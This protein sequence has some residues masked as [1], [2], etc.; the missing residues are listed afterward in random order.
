MVADERLCNLVAAVA[1]RAYEE[2][3]SDEVLSEE[4]IRVSGHPE[5]QVFQR[6][7]RQDTFAFGVSSGN[8]RILGIENSCD[9]A[10]LSDYLEGE[11]GLTTSQAVLQR[12]LITIFG[13]RLEHREQYNDRIADNCENI[14]EDAEAP[15]YDFKSFIFGL[16]LDSSL[17]I[18]DVQ[19]RPRRRN[20]VEIDVRRIDQLLPNG[21]ITLPDKSILQT[22]VLEHSVGGGDDL[23]DQKRGH[24]T[25][26]LTCGLL[27]L[28]ADASYSLV[29]TETDGRYFR[30]G[31]VV[32]Y[33]ETRIAA[34]NRFE[35]TPE[36][37]E[38]LNSLY[39]LLQP[40]TVGEFNDQIFEYPLSVAY[41]SLQRSWEYKNAYREA[42][43]W[44][45][46]GLE[47]VVGSGNVSG[48][49]PLLLSS[50]T[51]RYDFD[52]IATDIDDAFDN[53]SS[54]AH[55]GSRKKSNPSPQQRRVRDY[56]RASMVV[57][58]YLLEQGA[59][60]SRIDL[61]SKLEGSLEG[62]PLD[63]DWLR[64]ATTSFTLDDYLQFSQAVSEDGP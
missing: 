32:Q 58:A 59:V 3:L 35:A 8:I 44:L 28:F 48:C 53:R 23:E 52:D 14:T 21:S 60:D 12:L 16:D 37:Q 2:Y 64:T 20:D 62:E 54:W 34:D 33:P 57:Y 5:S 45:L 56:L 50:T 55:G 7:H 27:N 29:R 13:S 61:I 30:T 15:T 51:G 25:A 6:E 46:I 10:D 24:M 49:V 9:W 26:A 38:R 43:G 4:Y 39:S 22:S 19:L 47:S 40:H 11:Y 42:L 18:N 41:H 1:D 17:S 63:R 31:S 36:D